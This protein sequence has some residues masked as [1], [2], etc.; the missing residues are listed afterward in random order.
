MREGGRGARLSRQWA[1]VPDRLPGARRRG[2]LGA[3]GDAV[4]LAGPPGPRKH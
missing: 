1:A 3:V 4:M 2:A